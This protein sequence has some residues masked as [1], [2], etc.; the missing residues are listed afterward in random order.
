MPAPYD[1]LSYLNPH[2]NLRYYHPLSTDEDVEA[3]AV[4]KQALDVQVKGGRELKPAPLQSP[5]HG[6]LHV[7][8]FTV[9]ALALQ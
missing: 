9:G 5:V 3:E 8:E 1:A 2:T 4:R 7:T 6:L